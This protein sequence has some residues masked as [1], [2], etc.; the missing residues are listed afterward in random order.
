VALSRVRRGA[1]DAERDLRAE[2]VVFYGISGEGPP[3]SMRTLT[4]IDST[5]PSRSPTALRSR[6]T[7]VY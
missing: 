6:G 4:L 7:R 3:P 1:D 5:V 2:F